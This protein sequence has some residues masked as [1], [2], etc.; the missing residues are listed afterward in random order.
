MISLYREPTAATAAAGRLD[1][2]ISTTSFRTTNVTYDM[3]A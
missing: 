3:L 1:Y 2:P